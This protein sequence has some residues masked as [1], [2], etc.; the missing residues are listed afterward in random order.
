V[1]EQMWIRGENGAL[2]VFDLPL[3]LGIGH[4]LDSGEL[5][6]VN[7]DGTPYVEPDAPEPLPPPVGDRVP[8][9]DG[10]LPDGAPAL[11]GRSEAK[12]VWAA[13]AISQGMDRAQA[14][15]MT[16]AQLVAEFTREHG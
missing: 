12:H 1:A 14:A 16:K 11:P 2:L 4:R 10:P 3:P 13:F 9:D 6:R 8:A 5:V 15:T 7:E